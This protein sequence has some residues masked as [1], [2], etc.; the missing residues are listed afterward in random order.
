MLRK[1]IQKI[2][3]IHC[4]KQWNSYKK[5]TLKKKNQHNYTSTTRNLQHYKIKLFFLLR[6]GHIYLTF[7]T[8][9]IIKIVYSIKNNCNIFCGKL[10]QYFWLY[11][12]GNKN[13]INK[14]TKVSID[15]HL[16]DK[17]MIHLVR[18]WFVLKHTI[19]KAKLYQFKS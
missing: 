4:Y 13:F 2:L 10:K 8:H 19:K 3:Y 17:D 7:F 6:R 1:L 5:S 18:N 11:L 15:I 12:I 14:R 16:L 9:Y